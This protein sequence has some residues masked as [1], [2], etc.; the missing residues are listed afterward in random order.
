MNDTTRLDSFETAL[1]TELRREVAE[2]PAP[3][4]IAR[5]HPRRRLKV[6]AAGVVAAVAATVAAIGL[7]PSSAPTA[8]P[9]FAVDA[10]PDGSVGLV[11]HRL[12]D[13][14]G[15]EAALAAHGIDATVHFIP[16][17]DGQV[18]PEPEIDG[19]WSHER[20]GPENPCGVDN[21]PGPAM[22]VPGDVAR[23]LGR[24]RVELG[25]IPVGSGDFVLEF[26]ADSVLLDRPVVFDI[27]NPG[28][29]WITYPS[30]TPG[31]WCGFGQSQ[32]WGAPR[33]V[34]VR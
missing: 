9:A 22:L 11:I 10:G 2:H 4:P 21:G 13:A 24:N 6:A 17:P 32:V 30:T 5:R 33:S 27:G 14:D 16:T 26:P 19:S 8:A 28:S 15:L 34:E 7:T 1:L 23:G 31:E 20:P 12:D 3:A 25:T 29:F 18:P